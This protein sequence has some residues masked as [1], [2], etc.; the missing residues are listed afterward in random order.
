ME[1]ATSKKKMSV[2]VLKT[3]LAIEEFGIK[4]YT[5]LGECVADEGGRALM[6][7]LGN[8][9]KEHARMIKKEMD[10]LTSNGKEAKVEP[11]R[12][13]L[14]ILPDSVFVKPKDSCL[15][16]EDEIAALEKGIEVE[17]NS[18]RMYRDA[19][20]KEIDPETRNTVEELARWESRHREILEENLRSLK[21][22][23]AWY[24]Y[25]PILEG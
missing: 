14:G 7:S 19:L 13:Y 9:E 15:T 16:L 4:F 6:R 11:L 3:A 20:S 17:A 25:G 8:D 10:R 24:G 12:E 23:G 18:L 1:N 2:A 5:E 22:G 21:L